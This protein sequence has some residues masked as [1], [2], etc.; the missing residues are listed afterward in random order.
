MR[1]INERIFYSRPKR[2]KKLQK[3]LRHRKRE[4]RF[5]RF[6]RFNNTRGRDGEEGKTKSEQKIRR[7]SC[8]PIASSEFLHLLLLDWPFIY[9][10]QLEF[11]LVSRLYTSMSRS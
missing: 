4:R 5:S 6:S 1:S 9:S 3:V 11:S 10:R 7:R 2:R 8:L